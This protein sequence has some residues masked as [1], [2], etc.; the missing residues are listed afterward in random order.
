MTEYPSIDPADVREGDV[1]EADCWL[2]DGGEFTIR[3]AVRRYGDDEWAIG[4]RILWGG[5]PARTKTLAV[6]LI[7]RPAPPEPPL[8]PEPAVGSG[9][10][11]DGVLYLRR[12]LGDT[13]CW[14]S[15]DPGWW[16]WA[17]IQPCV[18][19]VPAERAV[20]SEAVPRDWLGE[21]EAAPVGTLAV[22]EDS[23]GFVAA[24]KWQAGTWEGTSEA[25]L[26]ARYGDPVA[27]HYPK[28]GA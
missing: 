2:H 19:A 23:V 18:P 25:N 3:G 6:R 16:S 11:H 7:S 9:V 21:M 8:P 26:I 1:V 13:Y 4:P 14:C 17:D 12:E 24:R 5:D 28:D 20:E 22:Y 10:F 27:L 15:A